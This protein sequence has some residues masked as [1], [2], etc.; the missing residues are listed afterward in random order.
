MNESISDNCGKLNRCKEF[1]LLTSNLSR[2]VHSE[3]VENCGSEKCTHL[4]TP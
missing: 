3:I 4:P 2:Q 1:F